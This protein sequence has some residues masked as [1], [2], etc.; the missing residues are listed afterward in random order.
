M[1]VI[2]TKL[3]PPSTTPA[4][5]RTALV[6]QLL[7]DWPRRL[8][9][10]QAPAGYGK[11]ALLTL[12]WQQLGLRGGARAWLTLDT[13]DNL[14]SRF[15][16][17]VAAALGLD[18]ATLPADS[19][20][21]LLI[22]A[23]LERPLICLFLDDLHTISEPALLTSLERLIAYA[24][25]QLQLVIASRSLPDWPLAQW[26]AR[27]QARL[28]QVAEL[29]L[30]LAEVRRLL[31]HTPAAEQAAMLAARTEGW[32][33]GVLLAAQLLAQGRL[34]PDQLASL[35]GDAAVIAEYLASEVLGQQP[36]ERQD[37][38]LRTALL[39]QFSAALCAAVLERADAPQLLAALLRQPVLISAVGAGDWWRYHPLFA[40]MLRQRLAAS[41]PEQAA[42]VYLR[43]SHWYAQ[44]DQLASAIS[45]ALRAG[46][47]EQAAEWIE[48]I[49]GPL[50]TE[51]AVAALAECLDALPAALIAARPG[52]SLLA[53]WVALLRGQWLQVAPYITHVERLLAADAAAS[54]MLMAARSQIVAIQGN[55]ALSQGDV[56]TAVGYAEQALAQ[57]PPDN[58]LM[59]GIL[60][61]ELGSL[62]VL[63]G[64]WSAAQAALR[65][66]HAD[67][68]AV[69]NL[70]S[71]STAAVLL[72]QAAYGQGDLHTSV[73]RW[74]AVLHAAPPSRIRVSAHYGLGLAAYEHGD[75]V[76]ATQ[77]AE[78]A[79]ALALQLADADQAALALSLRAQVASA[80][81]ELRAPELRA[82][83]AAEL[84]AVR[85]PLVRDHL[86]TLLAHAQI[87]A[88]ELEQARAWAVRP[89]PQPPTTPYQLET[90]LT[91]LHWRCLRQPSATLLDLARTLAAQAQPFGPTLRL[92]AA[93]LTAVCADLAADYAACDAAIS[94]ALALVAA[95]GLRQVW[96]DDASMVAP[97]L[98]RV[99][100][101]VLEQ[102]RSLGLA[103][104]P[105]LAE[106]LTP[107]E[108]D[109]LR[110]V[111]AGASNQQIAAALVLTV[112]TVKTHLNNA[113][114]K[115]QVKRRTAAVARA[116]ELGLLD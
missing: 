50:L 93:L 60:G 48:Q 8:T 19:A 102:A 12:L 44:Q 16:A 1:H 33:A 105:T 54:P 66:A 81:Q 5:P 27:Q 34:R 45:Y 56:A 75:L 79:R 99:S 22:E 32:A 57:I 36:A 78:Q 116:R 112:G 40:T 26:Q 76:S 55:L 63:A 58:Q 41:A 103:A 11:T 51:G 101:A 85:Q 90:A 110:M 71:A 4:L 46:A 7:A 80:R 13:E 115:L 6:D 47:V 39:D 18:A 28:V 23:L 15:W 37:F 73:E 74:Q 9:L 107:R 88:A 10:V 86:A 100:S 87:C 108:L 98:P 114:G 25:P 91:Q 92:R 94:A 68:V 83:L 111:A 42:L 17:A 20:V 84:S 82:Q 65:L 3:R 96:L 43:A 52:L 2:P 69:G 38:L 89:Q 113:Y 109:V 24:P 59:R 30:T 64:R 61:V 67:C 35:A 70:A 95:H 21:P 31:A 72:G 106:P 53:A 29:R 14:P 104:A 97:L 49:A 62:L 77:H